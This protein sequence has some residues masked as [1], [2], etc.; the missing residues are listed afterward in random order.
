MSPTMQATASQTGGDV[1]QVPSKPSEKTE[2]SLFLKSFDPASKA[3]VIKEIKTILKNFNLVEAKAFVES[4]PKLVKEKLKKD[5][6][7]SMKK[8]LEAVGAAVSV[9]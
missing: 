3:K 7:E 2:F 4:A 1:D 6:A 5:E 8:A 9:E